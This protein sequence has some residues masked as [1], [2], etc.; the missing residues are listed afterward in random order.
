MTPVLTSQ[1]MATSYTKTVGSHNIRTSV[2]RIFTYPKPQNNDIHRYLLCI[3]WKVLFF[4]HKYHSSK[5]FSYLNT[6]QFQCVRISDFLLYT[7]TGKTA[8]WTMEPVLVNNSPATTDISHPDSLLA[9]A[10]HPD[11]LLAMASHPD[12]FLAMASHPVS[13]LAMASHPLSVLVMPRG[14]S[15]V[16]TTLNW[17]AAHH[18]VPWGFWPPSQW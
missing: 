2:I 16:T 14:W 10:S 7:A 12:S 4:V 6:C 15:C 8:L 13:L 18:S 9:M 5:H 1:L 3:K 11:S 17:P